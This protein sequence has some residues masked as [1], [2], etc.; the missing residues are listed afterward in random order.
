MSEFFDGFDQQKLVRSVEHCDAVARKI[1][2][3]GDAMVIDDDLAGVGMVL[4]NDSDQD[5]GEMW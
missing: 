5:V 2:S 4:D 1:L 3:S